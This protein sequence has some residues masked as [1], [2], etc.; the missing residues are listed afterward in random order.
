MT[1]EN[2]VTKQTP[3]LDGFQNSLDELKMRVIKL[4]VSS[5]KTLTKIDP[6]SLAKTLGFISLVLGILFEVI[7]LLFQDP[8][9]Q[10]SFF[11]PIFTG[12]VGV[13]N[14]I[15][16]AWIYNWSAKWLGGIKLELER[17]D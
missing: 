7:V 9:I 11:L 4:E 13:L 14:G 10:F 3:E 2:S 5:E 8:N 6:L 12:L 1:I 15:L 17:L 16:V